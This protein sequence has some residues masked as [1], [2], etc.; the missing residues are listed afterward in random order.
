MTHLQELLDQIKSLE[1]RVRDEIQRQAEDFGYSLRRGRVIFE[2]DVIR[3]HKR[4]AKRL[5]R[6]L[7][8]SPL[9]NIIGNLLTAPVVYSLWLPFM[10]LDVFVTVYQHICF[11]VYGVPRVKRGDYIVIDRHRLRYLNIIERMNCFY[12]GYGNGVLAYVMEVGARTEQYWCPIKHAQALEQT[13]SR[14]HEFADYGDADSY[15]SGLDNLRK[16]LK[17]IEEEKPAP[18]N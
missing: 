4:K 12:C 16:K 13:R 2:R 7:F 10:L 8:S 6:Y 3:H 9:S 15:L 17:E 14:Y 18:S 11:R 1:A 5:W